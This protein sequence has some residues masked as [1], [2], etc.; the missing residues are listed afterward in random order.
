MT[1]AGQRR[2]RVT[3]QQRDVDENSDH[4]G[5][6]IEPG[7]TRWARAVARTRGEVILGQRVQG[8]QPLEVTILRDSQ[9]VQITTAWRLLWKGAVY[10]IKAVAPTEDRA[11]ISI[12]AEADQTNG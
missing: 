5:P 2:E 6:W 11:E 1:P 10:N 8:L 3:F 9:T 7:F 4:D 12:L